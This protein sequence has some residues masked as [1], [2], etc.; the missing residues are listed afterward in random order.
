M[1]RLVGLDALLMLLPG[2]AQVQSLLSCFAQVSLG[3][4]AINFFICPAR[5]PF[6]GMS[7]CSCAYFWQL[8]IGLDFGVDLGLAVSFLQLVHHV[9]V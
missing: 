4:G 3:G 8:A 6:L 2:A 5:L 7:C 1:K 9:T